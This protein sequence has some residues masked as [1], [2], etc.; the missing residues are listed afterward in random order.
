MS[1]FRTDFIGIGAAKCGTTWLHHCLEEHPEVCMPSPKKEPGFYDNHWEDWDYYESLFRHRKKA[2]ILGEFTP[3]YLPGLGVAERIA[4]HNPRAK[5]ILI[6]RNP[7][8]RAYSHYCMLH[9]SGALSAGPEA[10]T[11]ETRMFRDSMYWTSLSKYAERFPRKN[12]LI[13]I[14]EEMLAEP[15]TALKS[16]YHFLDVDPAFI[17]SVLQK[18]IHGRSNKPRNQALYRALVE[19]SNFA[20][21]TRITGMLFD[22]IRILG[23][24]KIYRMLD[25]GE[26]FPPMTEDVR[27]YLKSE[28][29]EEVSGIRKYTNL[30]IE[31]W[32]EDFPQDS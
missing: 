23:A 30:G 11:P 15:L 10:I 8:D 21:K 32:A 1:D 22:K 27:G 14:Q 18:R 16:I 2:Q 13:L 28:F 17:P 9:K 20:H 7:I 25:R 6:V 5:L 31:A 3:G 12:I 19:V 24:G 26:A 29:S 4:S